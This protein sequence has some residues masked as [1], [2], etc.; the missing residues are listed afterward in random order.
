MKPSK[1]WSRK[2]RTRS[3][4][5][6]P[7]EKS[8][9]V[10]KQKLWI[11]GIAIILIPI[12]VAWVSNTFASVIKQ[13]EVQGQF[14]EIAIDILKETPEE[15]NQKE[16]LRKWAI[17]IVNK[18]SG[19]P[20]D[21]AATKELTYNIPLLEDRI[22]TSAPPVYKNSQF[23]G[24]KAFVHPNFN[25]HL[26]KINELARSLGIELYITSS[27]RTSSNS[28]ASQVIPATRSKHLIGYA[29][30]V[31]LKLKDKFYNSK[32]LLKYPN[33]LPEAIIKFIQ[34]VIDDPFLEWGGQFQVKDPVHINLVVSDEEYDRIYQEMLNN[35]Y[36]TND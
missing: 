28:S 33:E 24:K 5:K 14:V 15:N 12:V 9:S 32:L 1:Y 17:E 2:Y 31:N 25:K 35:I 10:E 19:V 27:F 4:F 36:S 3:A 29:I 20:L 6:K 13:N 8:S 18:Y 21:S 30:D 16:N 26:D 11:N 23:I 34:S 7:N 22:I